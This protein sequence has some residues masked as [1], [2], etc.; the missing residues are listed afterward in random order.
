MVRGLRAFVVKSSRFAEILMK[1][2]TFI[3]LST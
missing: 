3:I 2:V 1:N